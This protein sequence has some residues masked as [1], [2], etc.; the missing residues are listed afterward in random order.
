MKNKRP[1]VQ[2]L[3]FLAAVLL[4]ASNRL[5]APEPSA[6]VDQPASQA[7]LQ[8]ETASPAV[9]VGL[10][11]GN[12]RTL[13]DHFDRH[14]ADFQAADPADYARQAHAFYAARAQYQVKTD[15]DGSLRVYDA[16]TNAF[17]AYNPDGTTKTY[18][19]PD[20]GQAYFY[21]QPGK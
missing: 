14:G 15:L 13:Q 6:P 8:A 5:S 18:F 2:I 1:W 19:K 10:H 11:W 4:I 21:R 12:P 3:L 16:Q 20:N 9:D 17:G 7:A